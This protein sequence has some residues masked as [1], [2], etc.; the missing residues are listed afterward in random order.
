MWNRIQNSYESGREGLTA[1]LGKA[2]GEIEGWYEG[3][4]SRL[5]SEAKKFN[6]QK[7]LA[8]EQSGSW[9]LGKGL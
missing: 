9:Y 6:N 4:K 5:S 3:E 8:Q 2:M 1:N 7:K